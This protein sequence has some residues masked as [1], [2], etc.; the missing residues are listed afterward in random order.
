MAK[1]KTIAQPSGLEQKPEELVN[2]DKKQGSDEFQNVF[3]IYKATKAN[4]A[5]YS[6]IWDRISQFVGIE[7]N[8]SYGYGGDPQSFSSTQLDEYMDDPTSAIS[9]NQAGDYLIGIMWGTGDLALTVQPSRY[10]KELL[11]D[12]NSADAYY[13]FATEQLLYQVNHPEAGLNASLMAYSYDQFAFGTSGVGAFNNPDYKLGITDNVILFRN[14]GVDNLN[15]D[16]GK[17][18]S[19][20][21]VFVDNIWRCNRIVE[22]FSYKN[23][24]FNQQMFNDLPQQIRDAWDAEQYNQFFTVVLGVIPRANYS[25]KFKGKRGTKYKGCWFIGDGNDGRFFFEE[26]FNKKPISVCRQVRVR[27]EVWGRSSGTLLLSTISAAQFML[28]EGIEII[29]K[30]GQ[31]PLAVNSNA[32]FGDSVLDTS[33]NGI[34]VLNPALGSGQEKSIYQLFDVGD[35]SELLKFLLP[36]LEGKITTAFKVDVLLDF[37]SAKDMSATESL[38]RYAIRGKSL[39]GTLTQ[40]KTELLLPLMERCLGLLWDNGQLGTPPTKLGQTMMDKLKRSGKAGRVIPPEVL[41]VMAAGLPWYDIKFNNE[42]EK[43]V[44]TEAIQNLTQ[45]IQAV[46]GIASLYPDI[47]HAIDWYKLLKDINDNLPTNNQIMLTAQDFKAA[48][49][50]AAQARAQAQGGQAQLAAAKD[51]SQTELNRAKTQEINGKLQTAQNA[52]ASAIY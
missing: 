39:A 40:Q 46:G 23:G 29:E 49:Q 4:K 50:S 14:F 38:Q 3:Q 51:Q 41:Q 21:I 44:R 35:P 20:D 17:S 30:M 45:I 6:S 5:R 24:V 33:S 18:G 27:G 7:V 15:I 26:D 25:P 2:K 13:N 22:E 1:R 34:T 8:P 42:L 36:Y 19:V 48:V 52:N 16:E 43:L 37:N 31:P 9:V 28:S 32:I 11:K 12:G 47:I 10:V